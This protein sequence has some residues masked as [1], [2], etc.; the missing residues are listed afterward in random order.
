MI[1][2]EKEAISFI[3]SKGWKNVE[4][5]LQ[6]IRFLLDKLGH[7]ESEL[8]V[9]HVA[10]TNGKGSVCSM[11]SRVFREA[12][13]K[14]GL[15]VS[16]YLCNFRERIQLNG[17]LIPKEALVRYTE[18]I[19]QAE[20]GGDIK[21]SEFELILAIAL[22]YYRD[23]KADVVVLET[24]LG[25]R[26]DPTN[27]FDSPLACV[28]TG[29]AMDHMQILGNTIEA[30]ASEKAGI[31]KKSVPVI[32]GGSDPAALSVIRQKAAD[33][34]APLYLS[35]DLTI[36]D[37]SFSHF[38]RK[39]ILSDGRAFETKLMGLYQE[40]NM[41]TVIKTVDVLKDRIRISERALVNGLKKAKWPG[42]FEYLSFDPVCIFDGGHN[43]EGV[44][45]A[46]DSFKALFPGKKACIVS[47][48]MADKDYRPMAKKMAEI[49]AHVFPV[50]LNIPR[51][52][53]SDS[54]GA[55]LS[56]YVRQVHES[57]SLNEA[58]EEAFDL[59]RK[60]HMP[61]LMLGSLY[62]YKPAKKALKKV[63]R[64]QI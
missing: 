16:P 25:G 8:K 1:Q 60:A 27:V 26:L 42:R 29:I 21:Y 53:N 59:C 13:Y 11:L 33:M 51:A 43:V 58:M 44:T 63:M 49:A 41:L 2:T 9:V 6:R 40:A 30:I 39:I 17:R 7:P 32:Y 19:R 54:Y 50:D 10:G 12:G 38:V 18:L 52:L 14:T 61:M 23:M 4:P 34:E 57:H 3:H 20:A 46:V 62:F 47:A 64:Q 37:S 35:R 15:F 48:V 5:G 28:I 31:I 22:C 45:A 56:E 55:V 36:Q 24:G